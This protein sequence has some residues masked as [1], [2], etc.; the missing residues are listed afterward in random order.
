MKI[1]DIL[2]VIIFNFILILFKI[3][4][5]NNFLTIPLLIIEYYFLIVGSFN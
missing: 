1:V 3:I 4:I 5:L 2:I